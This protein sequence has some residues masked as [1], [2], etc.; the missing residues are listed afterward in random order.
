MIFHLGMP[1]VLFMSLLANGQS[2][3]QWFPRHLKEAGIR[4]VLMIQM[5]TILVLVM[6][7]LNND[8]DDD[9]HNHKNDGDNGCDDWSY[10]LHFQCGGGFAPSAN[11]FCPWIWIFN[12]LSH[13]KIWYI[14]AKWFCF[15]EE[16]TLN[17]TQCL[18]L[19]ISV[20]LLI[21]FD[22]LSSSVSPSLEENIFKILS[23][24]LNSSRSFMAKQWF[25][26]L[27][28]PDNLWPKTNLLARLSPGM[29]SKEETCW[30]E[31]STAASTPFSSSHTWDGTILI[32]LSDSFL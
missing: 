29:V 13:F 16:L 1:V 10:L 19:Y 21:I 3:T 14:L 7:T 28:G 8:A 32:L 18:S 24:I 9:Y 5:S 6:L 11:A 23:Q 17:L 26:Q 22:I 15:F 27:L 2:E 30:A 20:E 4:T 12:K 25:P 31:A